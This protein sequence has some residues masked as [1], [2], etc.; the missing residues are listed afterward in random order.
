MSQAIKF[1]LCIHEEYIALCRKILHPFS[2]NLCTRFSIDFLVTLAAH[3]D[4]GSYSHS[5]F[6][7]VIYHESWIMIVLWIAITIQFNSI[8]K[9]MTL[10]YNNVLVNNKHF[11][12]VFWDSNFI[13]IINLIQLMCAGVNEWCVCVYMCVRVCGCWIMDNESW[14]YITPNIGENTSIARTHT[15]THTAHIYNLH[16]LWE[17]FSLSI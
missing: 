6:I 10:H 17:Y 3:S 12:S 15:H 5:V 1:I 9:S 13:I 2:I 4:F 8:K 7:F 11:V 14:S 16:V